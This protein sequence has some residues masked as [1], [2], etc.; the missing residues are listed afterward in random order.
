MNIEHHMNITILSSTMILQS[1]GHS[2][3]WLEPS[4][5]IFMV[6]YLQLIA[7]NKAKITYLH[8]FMWTIV[9]W[10]VVRIEISPCPTVAAE[11]MAALQTHHW[12][13]EKSTAANSALFCHLLRHW[14]TSLGT[15][16]CCERRDHLPRETDFK[17]K[18]DLKTR[19]R[20]L[21]RKPAPLQRKPLGRRCRDVPSTSL[22]PI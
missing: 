14:R 3:V 1:P 12:I 19:R 21:E 13:I 8:H 18:S 4:S 6:R 2:I 9:D 22:Y 5:I 10:I 17:W 15:H 16:L 7:H 11:G 20:G